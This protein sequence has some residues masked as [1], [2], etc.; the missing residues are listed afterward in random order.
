MNFGCVYIFREN[1]NQ[2]DILVANNLDS[3]LNKS[4]KNSVPIDEP[5]SN[6]SSAFL[7]LKTTLFLSEVTCLYEG[8]ERLEKKHL[9]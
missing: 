8:N 6:F 1:L 7:T 3:I 5:V 9:H 4:A 2:K